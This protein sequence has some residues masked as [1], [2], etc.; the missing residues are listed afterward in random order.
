MTWTSDKERLKTPGQ[1]ALIKHA[2]ESLDLN[3]QVVNKSSL[4]AAI[5]IVKIGLF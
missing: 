3:L 5:F 4:P 1:N 2:N